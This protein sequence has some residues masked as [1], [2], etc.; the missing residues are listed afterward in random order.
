MFH[1]TRPDTRLSMLAFAVLSAACGRSDMLPRHASIGQDASQ[2]VG[3][4]L[5]GHPWPVFGRDPQGTRCS[6][7]DTSSNAGRLKWRLDLGPGLKSSPVISED[8]T[9][10]VYSE[11]RIVCAVAPPTTETPAALKW[12]YT[13]PAPETP[14]SWESGRI[15]PS[16][17]IGPD[18][19]VYMS[20]LDTVLA[21]GATASGTNAVLKWSYHS[22]ERFDYLST[23]TVGGD[24]T[25]F[26]HGARLLALDP[27][28]KGT[29]GVLKWSSTSGGGMVGGPPPTVTP[30]GMVVYESGFALAVAQPPV[31]GTN[32]T[33]AGSFPEANLQSSPAIAADGTVY[34]AGYD[35]YVRAFVLPAGGKSGRLKWS[36]HT[37]SMDH[38]APAIG[39]DGTVY[40]AGGAYGLFAL[41]PNAPGPEG[42]LKWRWYQKDYKGWSG[43]PAV[44]ADGTI[45]VAGSDNV[46]AISPP[47]N[48][49][50]GVL[51][52]V[53][54]LEGAP[55]SAP[56][57]GADGTIY[58]TAD[59]TLYAIQ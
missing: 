48:G 5:Q 28:G 23:P 33:L 56:A 25:V 37:N 6:P 16:P 8:G 54:Q 27:Q 21:L 2:P 19:T 45:Y 26:V 52:W 7:A 57:I 10:Y 53:F 4:R 35:Q 24:G 59:T 30:D 38:T 20:T 46:H 29:M 44:G 34:V 55:V 9:I 49:G 11:D 13:A 43:W 12:I 42:E 40:V 41:N 17:A 51:K 3:C 50:D 32:G 18:G 31:Q 14:R 58:V 15:A 36:Y 39:P 1:A 47:T 22:S